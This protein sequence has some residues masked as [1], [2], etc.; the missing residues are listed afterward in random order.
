MKCNPLRWLFGLVP[1]LF[2][3]WLAVV[4]SRSSIEADLLARSREALKKS[5]LGWADV[6]FEG[7][8]VELRGKAVD[9][10][11]PDKAL[12]LLYDTWGVRTTANAA[13][14][15]DKVDKYEW[16]ATR[17]SNRI[18]LNGH[19]PSEKTRADIL[20]MVKAS[21]PGDAVDDQTKLARGAPPLD[22]WLG[23]VGFGLKQLAQ[24]KQGQIDLTQASLSVKGEAA[25]IRSFRSVKSALAGGLPKGVTLRQEEVKAPTVA[26][27]V[28]SAQFA[29]E[30][31]VLSGFVPSDKVREDILA[32]AKRV[33]PK[34]KIV[35]QM[36]PAEGAPQNFAAA[37]LAS[38]REMAQLEEATVSIRDSALAVTGMA[39]TA[40]KADGVRGAL[41]KDV[42][43]S[44]KTSE[45]IKHREPMI[46]PVSPY[47]T[48]AMLDGGTVVLTGFVPSDVA[49]QAIL[50]GARQRFAGRTVRDQMEIGAGQ[51]AGWQPCVEAGH[52]ALQRLGNGR[53]VL[54]DRRLEVSGSTD[55]EALAQALP[56]EVRGAAGG[57]CDT[58]VRVSLAPRVDDA[59]LKA[60]AEARLR[61]DAVAAAA[62]AATRQ[63]ADADARAKA[64]VARRTT[65][66]TCQDALRAVAR[67][68]VINFK[69]AS[70]EIE[71]TSFATLSK[72]AEVTNRCPDVAVEIEGHTDADGT[73][74]RNQRLSERRAQSVTD[75]LVRAGVVA[76][77]LRAVGYGETRGIAPNDTPENKARNRRIEFSVK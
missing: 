4:S 37:T 5:G 48:G 32:Q 17:A 51:P 44:F 77:R 2:L 76:G 23:G 15:I 22:A 52:A 1:I 25:D 62:A 75:Y 72:L 39:E 54:T 28:W 41:K 66:S 11:E 60:E 21:F 9:E 27:Y 8:D 64:E 70:A 14:L 68:G 55:A 33:A 29:K 24:L 74:E 30:Q 19:V 26:P 59:R 56:A 57:N 49:R 71:P 35:D 3:G 73:P 47:V 20:G 67:E 34:A 36:E 7:R 16:T 46:K 40:A 65:A 53:S 10:S 12:K 13:S 61:A 42:P 18:R 31:L 58:D 63:Q 45:Q 69:R 50:A 43:G 38:L 6:V